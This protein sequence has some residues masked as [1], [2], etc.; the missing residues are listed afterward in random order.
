MGATQ[1]AGMREMLEESACLQ[2]H[3]QYNHY[4]PL[5]RVLIGAC[6]ET[7]EALRDEDYDR[8]IDMPEGLQFQGRDSAM[9][10]EIADSAHLWGLV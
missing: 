10:C 7:L 1:L 6:Q 9:A 3:L 8:K 5:P 2:W 4:P